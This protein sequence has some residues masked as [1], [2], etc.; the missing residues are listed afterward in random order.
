[1]GGRRRAG[2]GFDAA[3]R[4]AARQEERP[5]NRLIGETHGPFD[6]KKDF[7]PERTVA[8]T[9]WQAGSRSGLEHDLDAA[10]R[11]VAEDL[12]PARGGLQRQVVSGELADAPW[13]A[14]V[15]DDRQ[16][17]VDPAP[18]VATAASESL[19]DFLVRAW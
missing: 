5:G 1:M 7:H 10:L 14:V 12:L 13:V 9:V 18:A 16:Q 15:A 8:P 11:L 19:I 2:L 4:P 3:A 6:R 17:A